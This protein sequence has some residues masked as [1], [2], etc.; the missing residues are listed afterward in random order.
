MLDQR[1]LKLLPSAALCFH[2]QPSISILK[3]DSGVPVDNPTW[4]VNRFPRCLDVRE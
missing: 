1:L 4:S 2:P 3:V